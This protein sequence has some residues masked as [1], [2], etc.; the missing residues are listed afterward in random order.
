MSIYSNLEE[1]RKLSNASLTSIVDVTNLNFKSLSDATLG[2]LNNIKYN[3]VDNSFSAFKGTFTNVDVTDKMSFKLDGIPTFTINSLGKAEGRELLV[4]VS[5]AKRRR[6]TDF[7]DWPDIGVPGE[8]IYTGIQNQ[9]PEFGEDFIGYLEHR[10][11]VSLTTLSSGIPGLVLIEQDGSPLIPPSPNNGEGIIWIGAPGAET[12]A[13][14][15][16]TTI[17]FTDDEGHTF[18]ILT[19]Q[20]WEKIGNDAKFRL[21]GK[22]QIGDNANPGA[23]QF[24]DGNQIPGYVMTT[25]G[26]GNA[27][28]AP[29]TGGGAVP[30]NFSYWEI[31]DFIAD[32]TKT[33]TH[34]LGTTNVVV[35]L[36]D[37][38]TNEK[39]GGHIDNY[40]NDSIDVTLTD[41][42][43]DVKVVVVSAGGP[44]GPGGGSALQVI[45]KDDKNLVA[46]NTTL[47]G[48]LASNT[49]ITNTPVDGCYVEVRV[50]G[51][52]Y[53]VGDATTNAPC[54][55]A[56]P[57]S[58]HLPKS[59]GSLHPNGQVTAGD[60]LYWNASLAG[61]NLSAGRRISLIYL[62]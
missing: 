62:I 3:E 12:N 36:I 7:T 27:Y 41:N 15:V 58:P 20:I 54:Y 53:E 2:F 33:I 49:P 26:G 44:P 31:S 5:E 17:Y 61:F 51:V 39:I 1:I 40:Q 4:V 50:N 34:D 10:G 56:T 9:R 57:G 30:F 21:P 6:F 35:D 47:D 59:F 13:D 43:I 8:I 25:D 14:P 45:S 42:N 24:V 28:W 23:F 38:I 32:I 55:F 11:W 46:L 29:P 48:D 18:D 16:N 22:A 37:T 52:E 19:D 60:Y